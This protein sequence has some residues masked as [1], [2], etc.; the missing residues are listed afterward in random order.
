MWISNI[1]LQNYRNFPSLDLSF[2]PG[3]NVIIAPN[4]SGKT[5]I[6]EAISY[7]S[8]PK[9]FRK[10]LDKDLI[11][12]S[13]L[14]DEIDVEELSTDLLKAVNSFARG[15]GEISIDNVDSN[16]LEFFI[17][18]NSGTQKVLKVNGKK[19]RIAGFVG[20]FY[21]V[22]F[23]PEIIDL[24]NSSPSKRRHLLDRLIATFEPDYLTNLSKYKEVLRNRNRILS[25]SD[26]YRSD[27]MDFW[28][29]SL[30]KLGAQILNARLNFFGEI[31]NRIG[32]VGSRIL[33]QDFGLEIYYSPMDSIEPGMNDVDQLELMFNEKL[34]ESQKI[35]IRRG[36]TT[37]GPHRDDFSILMNGYDISSFGSRGQQRI[38]IL[39]LLFSYV[40]FLEERNQKPVLLLDDVF[41][42]L[43]ENHRKLLLKFI[44]SKG[45]QVIITTTD[46]D[47]ELDS[48]KNEVNIIDIT[49]VTN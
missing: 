5:N 10:V 47:G 41:S 26:H 13:I 38:G 3:V 15:V 35:D 29:D 30:V 8:V 48:V 27:V 20:R 16:T 21:S 25:D 44:Q 14:V 28:D 40:L 19:E 17:Q 18:H 1:K 49:N 45:F 4:G 37:V 6:V 33:K 43:D 46:L 11:H 36:S 31:G 34:R 24:V 39:S 32:D 22:I 42:E 9:S 23:S 2:D 7:L 12:K